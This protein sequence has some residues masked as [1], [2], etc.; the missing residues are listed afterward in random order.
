VIGRAEPE[1]PEPRAA[2]A[3]SALELAARVN[4]AHVANLAATEIADWLR[5]S[6]FAEAGDGLRLFPTALGREVGAA[7][8]AF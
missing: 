7:L 3:V 5:D 8:A 4:R 1:R 6:G 2:S